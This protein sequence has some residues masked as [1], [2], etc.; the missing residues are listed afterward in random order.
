M[1]IG[2]FGDELVAE[3][4]SMEP[5]GAWIWLVKITLSPAQVM[6]LARNAEDVDFLSQ[7]WRAFT[8]DVKDIR[9]SAD[10]ELATMAVSIADVDGAIARIVRQH[11]GLSDAPVTVH[12][13]PAALFATPTD[14]GG[15]RNYVT[16]ST[17]VQLTTYPKAAVVFQLSGASLMRFAAPVGKIVR[18]ACPYVF[19]DPETC[20]AVTSETLCDHTLDG[21]K[22]CLHHNN[23][24]NYGG[25]PGVPKI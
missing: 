4:N 11:G 16:Y 23:V 14:G 6:Y 17:T 18:A 19:R 1:P 12:K 9:E 10:G 5:E 24:I 2:E 22:G 25:A 21:T 7:T 8:F 3:A 13:V 20:M 15:R